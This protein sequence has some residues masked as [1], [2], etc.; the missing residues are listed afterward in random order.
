MLKKKAPEAS[1]QQ[2][3]HC[4]CFARNENLAISGSGFCGY[5]F[6][7]FNPVGFS[8]NLKNGTCDNTKIITEDARPT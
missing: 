3:F 8:I 7:Y 5:Y 1:V 6:S 4:P 2:G